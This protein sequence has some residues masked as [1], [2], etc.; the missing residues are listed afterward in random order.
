MENVMKNGEAIPQ[1]SV[2][3]IGEP[4]I[5]FAQY[6][7]GESYIQPLSNEQVKMINVTFAPGCRNFWHIHH[8]SS[9]G[10]QMLIVTAGTGYYQ[11]WGE[12][13]RKVVTGDIVHIPAGVKHWH[14]ASA[15][16]W[17][18]H[19]AVEVFGENMSNEWFEPLSDDEYR[20]CT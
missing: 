12:P 8:A 19:I 3:P 5:D 4:N 7:T 6:F 18:Q 9:G 20:A 16:S 1:L 15:T 2:F 14:G 10:G 13:A 17:F 11:E